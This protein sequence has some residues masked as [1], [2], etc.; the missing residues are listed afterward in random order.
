MAQIE[1]L[2]YDLTRDLEDR[3]HIVAHV[4]VRV[5][6]RELSDGFS[7]TGSCWEAKGSWSG[8]RRS[9]KAAIDPEVSGCIHPAIL[10]AFPTL[11]GA[12]EL[13][14]SDL[15][16]VPMHA[17]ANGLFYY[18]AAHGFGDGWTD[19]YGYALRENLTPAAYAMRTACRLLRVEA[20]ELD[21]VDPA[22]LEFAFEEFVTA[23]RPRWRQEA[24][25]V[26]DY[27]KHHM[28]RELQTT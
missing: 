1:A 20:I 9:R 15:D 14:L 4:R 10:A 22:M 6:D 28:P 17:A 21:T 26:Y 19:Q 12:I 27:L 2:S 11:Q 13:H 7:V 23:Q 5:N 24:L 3:S 8:L 16:G 18:R 25:A